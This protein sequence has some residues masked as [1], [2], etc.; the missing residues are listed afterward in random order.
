MA[1]S[2]PIAMLALFN[3][4]TEE[5][6]FRGLIQPALIDFLGK[7]PGLVFQGLFFGFLHWGSS[8]ELIAGLPMALAATALG[9]LW[10]YSVICTRGIA[11]AVLCH[12]MADFAFFS[13]YFV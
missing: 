13:A 10:G 7:W 6:L 5:F 11:W 9:I 3:G 4:F 1:K 2:L 12:A 8:P